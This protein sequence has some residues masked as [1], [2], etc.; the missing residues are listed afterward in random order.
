MKEEEMK[1]IAQW[2]S[3]ILKNTNDEELQNKIRNQVL[4]LCNKF[5]LYA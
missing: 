1:L 2:I 3:Q 5:P 4:E